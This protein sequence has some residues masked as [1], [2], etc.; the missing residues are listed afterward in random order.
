MPRTCPW[1][2]RRAGNSRP[3]R[4]PTARA[5]ARC[6][7]GTPAASRRRN[8]RAARPVVAQDGVMGLAHAPDAKRQQ[9]RS[10]DE[11]RPQPGGPCQHQDATDQVAAAAMARG[12]SA[13]CASAGSCCRSFRC[14][15]AI[16]LPASYPEHGRVGVSGVC[17]LSPAGTALPDRGSRHGAL[18]R[19]RG[20]RGRAGRADAPE[21]GRRTDRAAGLASC[22]SDPSLHGRP[23]ASA[24]GLRD[25]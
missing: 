11:G 9:R 6:R 25:M 17:R 1:A 10:Q 3:R 4:A 23:R 2:S 18:R 12:H 7:R 13:G 5:A 21:R 19:E 22:G 14:F 20:A 16:T 8:A 15:F 24:R